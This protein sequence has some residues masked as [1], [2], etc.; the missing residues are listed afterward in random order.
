MKIISK[1]ADYYDHVAGW[2]GHDEGGAV[3]PRTTVED[4]ILGDFA[5]TKICAT[6][7]DRIRRGMYYDNRAHGYKLTLLV[8]VDRA[9]VV[10][11]PYADNQAFMWRQWVKAN[12]NPEQRHFWHTDRDDIDR[13]G[14][15]STAIL[16]LSK[17]VGRPVYEI[18]L[19]HE[20]DSK[21]RQF[22]LKVL[23]KPPILSQIKGFASMYEAAQ[24][25]QDIEYGIVNLLNPSP[26]MAGPTAI[27][28]KEKIVSHGFDLVQSF[29]HRK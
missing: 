23:G 16:E 1:F 7:A 21:L 18:E 25:Y 15:P 8:V 29:R 4:V 17:A 19:T 2:Y 22:K 20:Y 5:P 26:D 9:W 3:Y 11:R 14:K 6:A 28:D 13:E 27:T 10:A 24:I 12:P